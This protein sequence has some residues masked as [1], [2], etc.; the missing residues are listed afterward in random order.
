MISCYFILLMKIHKKQNGQLAKPFIPLDW[1]FLSGRRG[2]PL[3]RA[4]LASPGLPPPHDCPLAGL[5]KL[6]FLEYLVW[7]AGN[8]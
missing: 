1:L 5:F 3:G 4:G 6:Q 7:H 2:H 8:P